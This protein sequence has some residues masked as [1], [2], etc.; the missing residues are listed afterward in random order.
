MWVASH[1]NYKG[2]MHGWI[3][4]LQ[5]HTCESDPLQLLVLFPFLLVS[6]WSSISPG[7]DKDGHHQLQ[8]YILPFEQ[9]QQVFNFPSL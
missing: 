2:F 1:T 5:L 3:Q 6:F 8:A 7:D 9:S 4:E